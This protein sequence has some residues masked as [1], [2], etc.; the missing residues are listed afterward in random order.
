MLKKIITLGVVTAVVLIGIEN[1]IAQEGTDVPEQI[2]RSRQGR[3]GRP[4]QRSLTRQFSG[5]Q[6][7]DSEALVKGAETDRN[8]EAMRKKRQQM[9]EQKGTRRER[10]GRR[11]QQ[12]RPRRNQPMPRMFGGRRRGFQGRAMGGWRRGYQCVGLCPCCQIGMCPWYGDFSG[13]GIGG[14]V[15]SFRGRG[16]IGRGNRGF[17]GRGMGRWDQGFQP[18]GMGR[19]GAGMPPT[20]DVRPFPQN[21]P[22]EDVLIPAPPMQRRGMMGRRGQG[23]RGRGMGWGFP[24]PRGPEPESENN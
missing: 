20:P 21:P 4:R 11:L 16:M 17:Q 10:M 22:K 24:G 13:R 7:K 9:L 12:T 15:Q 14:R 23:F 5:Q 18:Q 19:P 6:Q 2:P 1:V 3:E 8:I